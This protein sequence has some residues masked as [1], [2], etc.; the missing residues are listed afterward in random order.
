MRTKRSHYYLLVV[1]SS[2][3]ELPEEDVRVAKITVSSPFGCFVTKL[4]RNI[5]SLQAIEK[6][7][8]GE[9]K[10]FAERVLRLKTIDCYRPEGSESGTFTIYVMPT[11]WYTWYSAVQMAHLLMILDGLCE[12]TQKIVGVAEISARPSLGC[13]IGYLSH[14]LEILPINQTLVETNTSKKHVYCY[15]SSVTTNQVGRGGN[16]KELT[17]SN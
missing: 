4:P 7:R 5:Q 11:V 9:K 12:T 6:K 16:S 15:Y 8:T 1:F 3:L 17:R 2:R 13:P 14:E 10:L